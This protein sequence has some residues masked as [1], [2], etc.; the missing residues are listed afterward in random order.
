MFLKSTA[1]DSKIH[2]LCVG[3][4]WSFLCSEHSTCRPPGCKHRVVSG[5]PANHFLPW[6]TASMQLPNSWGRL[7]LSPATQHSVSAHRLPVGPSTATIVRAHIRPCTWLPGDM[8]LSVDAEP[9]FCL[10]P[11]KFN[12]VFCFK[13]VLNYCRELWLYISCTWKCKKNLSNYCCQYSLNIFV[14]NSF[15]FWEIFVF[16][17]YLLFH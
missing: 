1:F 14:H 9:F 13:L 6:S 15:N 11:L 10:A 3:V 4:V 16:H 2:S 7:H 12:S 17:Y 5:E 8:L